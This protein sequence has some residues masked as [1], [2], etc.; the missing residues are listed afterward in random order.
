MTLSSLTGCTVRHSRINCPDQYQG[1]LFSAP[2]NIKVSYSQG[3]ANVPILLVSDSTV[4][5]DTIG[6][7]GGAASI[8]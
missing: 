3:Y 5:A 8:A 7:A 4:F 2:I 1:K 6:G